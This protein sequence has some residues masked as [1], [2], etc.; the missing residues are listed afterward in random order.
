MPRKSKSKKTVD[1]SDKII[2]EHRDE[3][4]F[5]G[6]FKTIANEVEI[7][8]QTIIP[9]SR[10]DHKNL[11]TGDYLNFYDARGKQVAHG[12]FHYGPSKGATGDLRSCVGTEHCKSNIKAESERY[13]ARWEHN[14]ISY[15]TV[16]PYSSHPLTGNSQHFS[17]SL[18]NRLNAYSPNYSKKKKYLLIGGGYTFSVEM[19][20]TIQIYSATNELLENFLISLNYDPTEAF[21]INNIILN[22]FDKIF[23]INELEFESEMI[24]KITEMFYL[25]HFVIK[26][27]IKYYDQIIPTEDDSISK[28]IIPNDVLN[29]VPINSNLSTEIKRKYK[30]NY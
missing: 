18:I 7:D 24:E 3:A 14:Q 25:N 23:T 21:N 11:K 27:L 29:E 28:E 8:L 20:G 12:S 2:S 15:N 16:V 17:A 26:E 1:S 30:I 9:G 6:L 13:I 19:L 5:R 10:V 22:T 4:N